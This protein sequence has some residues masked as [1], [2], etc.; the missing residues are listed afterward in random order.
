MIALCYKIVAGL[1]LYMTVLSSYYYIFQLNRSCCPALCLKGHP[2]LSLSLSLKASAEQTL[3]RLMEE[4]SLPLRSAP[5][6]PLGKKTQTQAAAIC[7]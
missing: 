4:A 7:G 5:W 1:N 2:P 3:R 6:K